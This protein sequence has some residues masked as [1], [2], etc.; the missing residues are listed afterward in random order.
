M[1]LRMKLRRSK[2]EGLVG[3]L[4]EEGKIFVYTDEIATSSIDRVLTALILS[5]QVKNDVL[6]D[7]CW[8]KDMLFAQMDIERTRV[9]INCW[10]KMIM[11][12]QPCGIYIRMVEKE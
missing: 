4:I 3:R 12:Q 9:F 5:Q 2:E 1:A 6:E 11:N 8:I 10:H 7:V